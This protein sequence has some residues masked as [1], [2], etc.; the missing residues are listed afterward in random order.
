MLRLKVI[1]CDVLNRE[2]SL[3]SSKSSC[4]VDTTFLHQGLHDTP[5]KLNRLLQK[6]IAKAN[7]GFPYNHFGTAPHFDY[8]V[9]GYGLCSNGIVGLSSEKIPLVIPRAHD[10]ITLLLGSKNRYIEYFDQNP[11]TYWFSAGW[12][13]RGWQPS[14]ARYN[15]LYKEYLEKYGKENAEYL[16]EMEQSW[17]KDYKNAALIRW[18]D[19]GSSEYYR[20]FTTES[21]EYLHWNYSEL[22]GDPSLLTRLLNAEF[23]EPE[24]LV[25]P[26]GKKAAPTYTEEIIKYI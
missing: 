26:P 2:I 24:V 10:C 13:E 5:E 3:L 1:A 4:F 17:M 6:E 19:L 12:V 16:M 22:E 14:E 7:E 9:L 20:K 8:I 15:V 25:V 11:G 23:K 18:N 21:A